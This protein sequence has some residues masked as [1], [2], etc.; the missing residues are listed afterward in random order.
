MVK[1]LADL[2]GVDLLKSDRIGLTRLLQAIA[3]GTGGG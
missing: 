1:L 3:W 2:E